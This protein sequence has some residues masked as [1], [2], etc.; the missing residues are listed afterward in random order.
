MTC[1]RE[2]WSF[3]L[4]SPVYFSGEVANIPHLLASP[5]RSQKPSGECTRQRA[6]A[7]NL[8]GEARAAGGEAVAP[9]LLLLQA[10]RDLLPTRVVSLLASTN[11]TFIGEAV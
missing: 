3:S 5:K 2:Q 6:H 11:F 8:R 1:Y 4:L 10:W 9:C 7:S